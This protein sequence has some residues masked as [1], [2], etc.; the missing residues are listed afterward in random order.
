MINS[1]REWDWMDNPLTLVRIKKDVM[2]FKKI[3]DTLLYFDFQPLLF[4][5]VASDI[6]NNQ[7]LWTTLEYW[8]EAGQPNTYWLYFIYLIM[9]VSMM[10]S[11]HNTKWLAR[12]VTGFLILNLF[13]TIRYLVNI[14]LTVDTEPFT[15]VD[16]K[17]ILIT[18][19]YSF[20]WAWILFKL[21][22]ELLLNSFNHG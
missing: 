20:M 4:F 9:S 10:I 21:K 19:W 18:L 16:I 17:N 7:V 3:K 11:L 13:S 5:W 2:Y 12:F 15:L 1:G 6:L 22:R 8:T 14:Y